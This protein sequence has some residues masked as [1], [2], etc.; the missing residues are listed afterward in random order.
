ML[1]GRRCVFSGVLFLFSEPGL[2][3]KMEEGFPRAGPKSWARACDSCAELFSL[4]LDA[5]RPSPSGVQIQ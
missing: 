5:S 2:G 3:R 4:P 1:G